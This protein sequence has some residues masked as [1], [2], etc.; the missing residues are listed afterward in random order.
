MSDAGQRRGEI[1]RLARVG[2]GLSREEVAERAGI[3]PGTV[4]NLERDTYKKPQRDKLEAVCKV[5][6]LDFDEVMGGVDASDKVRRGLP[7]EV[8]VLLDILGG[9]LSAQPP[10]RRRREVEFLHQHMFGES[11]KQ[12]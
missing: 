2:A 1:L 6:G 5:L 9:W 11:Q 8:S 3:S 4:Q 10:D 12:A 7:P